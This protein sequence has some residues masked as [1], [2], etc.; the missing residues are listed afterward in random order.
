MAP[1]IDLPAAQFAALQETV[2]A[3]TVVDHDGLSGRYD[4]KTDSYAF[5]T[6][7]IDRN[8]LTEREFH[9]LASDH[10]AYVS[11]WYFWA[12]T[13]GDRGAHRVAFLRWLEGGDRVPERYDALQSG[14]DREWGQLRITVRLDDTGDRAYA[15][16][17]ADDA[18]AAAEDL[19]AHQDPLDA[20]EIGTYDEAGRYRP[21]RTA[22]SLPTGWRFPDLDAH[23]IYEAVEAVY[24]ATV[25]NWHRER[26]GELDVDHWREAAARQTG[27]YKAVQDLPDEAVEW[28]AGACCVDSQCTKRREWELDSANE[29]DADSG[30]GIYPCREPCSLVVAAARKWATLE[31]EEPR[32]YEFE[33]TPSEKQQLEAMID[34]I[35]DGE[36][37]AI[38]E[39]DV[40]EGANRYR[41]RYLREKRIDD[42]GNL[43]GTPTHPDAGDSTT[44]ADDNDD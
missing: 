39:A 10:A 34:A 22:P 38:R 18:E 3:G 20:R 40:A 44:A 9:A 13:V 4:A 29:L 30:D 32:T 43:A 36:V 6:P 37:D 41:V 31:E 14:R 17:H 1:A 11:N 26:E 16:R 25:A 24:P 35:A 8:G 21:L 33:L 2:E 27:I 23:G 19:T 12:E 15:I 28:V 7:E 42:A 5:A